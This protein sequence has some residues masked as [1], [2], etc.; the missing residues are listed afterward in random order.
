MAQQQF[1]SFTIDPAYPNLIMLNGPIT[2]RSGLEFRRALA[3]TPSVEGVILN[4]PGGSVQM[5]L[6]IAEEIFE[7]QLDTYIPE[8][9]TCESAC[10]WVFFAG[11][12]RIVKGKLGVHQIAGDVEDNA[13]TQLNLSDVAE[14]LHKYGTPA[15]VLSAM[16]RTPPESMYYFSPT[17]VDQL[18][19]SRQAPSGELASP[20]LAAPPRPD[21]PSVARGLVDEIIRTHATSESAALDLV[22]KVYARQVS[23]FGKMASLDD[24]LADKKRYF[25]RHPVRQVQ[26]ISGSVSVTCPDDV[27]TVFGRYLWNIS[28][29]SGT[30]VFS[31]SV[32]MRNEPTVIA[33]GGAVVG[34]DGLLIP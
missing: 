19:L 34:A 10:S 13:L 4:S 22:R 30:A 6:M 5:G 7:R 28:G 2:D 3:A 16:L 31:Y 18:G 21:K 11:R 14:A 8:G 26:V 24:I 33:E 27:C 1:G 15:E 12:T 25:Q 29:K 20:T 32:D 17:E 9:F 23:Y